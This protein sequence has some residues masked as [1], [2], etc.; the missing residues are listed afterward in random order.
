M[1]RRKDA[2]FTLIELLVVIAIIAILA[3]LL[4]PA[5]SRAKAS[6]AS[7]KCKNNLRQQ[8]LALALYISDY[9]RYPFGFLT[10]ANP[11]DFGFY[12]Y[13]ALYPYAPFNRVRD[14]TNYQNISWFSDLYRC[15]VFKGFQSDGGGFGPGLPGSAG[16]YSYNAIGA[17]QYQ[18]LLGL[19]GLTLSEGCLGEDGVRFPSEMYA[20]ADARIVTIDQF[21]NTP[22]R[23]GSGCFYLRFFEQP[24]GYKVLTNA[25]HRG[26]YNA[27]FCD[28]HLEPV[29]YS[30]MYDRSEKVRRW[31]NDYEPH[32][33]LDP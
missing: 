7:T 6:A 23:A 13:E 24:A 4:L 10:T 15:P 25:P 17:G 19:G 16:C 32:M 9:H 28:G 20:I 5:L 14:S 33:P 31:N 12:W 30:A 1:N 29:K 18:K 21:D 8:G 26:A 22:L 2:A 3:S 11:A 27:L